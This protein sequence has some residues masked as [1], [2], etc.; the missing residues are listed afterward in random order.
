M[1]IRE[2]FIH[3]NDVIWD[4]AGAQRRGFSVM[5]RPTLEANTVNVAV[6]FCSKHDQFSKKKAREIL[7][8]RT[9][10]TIQVRD[11]PYFLQSC[12]DFC[13]GV[14]RERSIMLGN[15]WAWVWKYFL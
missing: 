2:R 13:W 10:D 14:G 8:S 1:F 15:N 6:A 9:G 5:L 4:D 3:Y 12:Q 7:E 11:L